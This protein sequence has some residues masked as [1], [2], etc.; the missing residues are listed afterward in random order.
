MFVFVSDQG[1][2]NLKSAEEDDK[3]DVCFDPK[4]N[5]YFD[6]RTNKYYELVS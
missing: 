6:P 5:C 3:L 2:K 4:L 1:K